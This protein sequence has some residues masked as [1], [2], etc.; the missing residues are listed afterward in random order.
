MRTFVANCAEGESDVAGKFVS[1]ECAS[2]SASH[3]YATCTYMN[4]RAVVFMKN[5]DGAALTTF[6]VYTVDVDFEE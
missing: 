6:A 4:L 2:I 5:E 3:T 1:M